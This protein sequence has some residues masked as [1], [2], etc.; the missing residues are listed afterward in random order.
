MGKFDRQAL[1]EA[2]KKQI[3]TSTLSKTVSVNYD[4]SSNNE[5]ARIFKSYQ[6]AVTWITAN[7][8]V[9]SDANTWTVILPSGLITEV[10]TKYQFI[11][12]R[13]LPFL[14]QSH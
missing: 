4:L 13:L 7:G 2:L 10:I 9:L 1:H 14:T 11:A 12:K 5:Q 6:D 3:G 8:G